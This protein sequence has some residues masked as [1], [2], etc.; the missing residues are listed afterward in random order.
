MIQYKC[1]S[2]G[3]EMQIGGSGGFVCPYCG[4][5]TFMTDADFKGNEEFRKKL[6]AYYKAEADNKE[7]DYATD[8]LW[9]CKGE[10]N[11]IMLNGQNLSIK[12]MHKYDYNGCVCY[13]A[14]ESV[15]YIFTD[16]ME[17]TRFADGLKKLTFPEAD[18]KLYRCFPKLKMEV[19]LADRREVMA[20]I[21]RPSFFPMELFSPWDS[22]HMAW[23]ISRMENIC[24]TLKFSGIWHGGIDATSIWVNPVTH[25]GALFGDWRAVKE[26]D[27]VHD[28]EDLRRTAI[29]QVK[30]ART[31]I[32]LYNFLNSKPAKDAF[33]DFA[34]WDKVIE[35]G[36]GGHKFVKM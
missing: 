2:C 18:V 14:K 5:K 34:M 3:G 15:V 30:D 25:E 33:E 13:L 27:G 36:F 19:S 7:F 26:I 35:N 28:L 12:Y 11:F 29:E 31:P 10:D 8:T 6:L 9:T 16:A 17:K 1:R 23:V 24:C 32:E 22:R 4:S 21:R 20:F